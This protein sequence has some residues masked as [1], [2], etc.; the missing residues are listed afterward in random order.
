VSAHTDAVTAIVLA[1][2]AG[3]RMKSARAKVLHEIGGRSMIEHALV[4]V[5]GA[6]VRTTVA[7]VGH[8]REQVSSAISA[9]DPAVVLAVQEEQNGTG[10]ASRWRPSTPRRRAPSS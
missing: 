4:A 10:C 2:G 1:A 6:G 9:H 5:A 3:T 8:D 7:V